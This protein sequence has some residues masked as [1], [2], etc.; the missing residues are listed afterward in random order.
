MA[1]IESWIFLAEYLILLFTLFIFFIVISIA[2]YALI[3]KIFK[4]NE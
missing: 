3:E 4:I 1:T 2:S